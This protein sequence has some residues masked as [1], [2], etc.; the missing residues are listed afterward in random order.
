MSATNRGAV[1][2][3]ADHY[4][5]PP[6]VT[7]RLLESGAL[8]GGST[9]WLEPCAGEGAIVREVLN[10]YNSPGALNVWVN[11][12]RPECREPLARLVGN[13]NVT[14]SDFLSWDNVV[15]DVI[16]T[17]PPFSIAE[18]VVLKALSARST[19]VTV[20]P[21]VA[22]LVRQGFVGHAR[23]EWMRCN[24]PDT[25]ELP[26]RP[27]FAASLRCSCGWKAMQPLEAPRPRY[28]PSCGPASRVRTTTSDAAD[29]CWLVW[30][31]RRGRSAGKRV[32]LPS[33][34][35]EERRLRQGATP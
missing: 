25:Y 22:V 15:A 19:D 10:W 33:T 18:A 30:G 3:E 7:R 13:E 4:P 34:P 20:A 2:I 21:Y 35:L 8:P 32:I 23:A 11:E 9:S 31:P 1:R 26:D 14:I 12:L 17:N 29:Y 24:M 16:I 28:C 27:S 6:W 5:T